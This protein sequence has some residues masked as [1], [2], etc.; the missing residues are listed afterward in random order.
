MMRNAEPH[1]SSASW[2]VNV[3]LGWDFV[4]CLEKEVFL[5]TPRLL[6]GALDV[7]SNCPPCTV[8]PEIKFI[9]RM[10]EHNKHNKHVLDSVLSNFPRTGA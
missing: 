7:I 10:Q 6:D 5:G 9:V 2:P 4:S 3:M 1:S 8:Q